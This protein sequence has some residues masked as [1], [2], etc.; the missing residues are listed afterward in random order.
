MAGYSAGSAS[1]QIV[2]DFSGAQKKIG[3][4]FAQQGDI[5][6][7][8]SPNLNQ[9][10]LQAVRTEINATDAAIDVDIDLH[11]VEQKMAVFLDQATGFSMVEEQ[12][13]RLFGPRSILM[14]T[15]VGAFT[16]LAASASAALPVIGLL[17]GMIMAAAGP[18]AV[19]AIGT[20][21][22]G[23]AFKALGAADK[24]SAADA[25][26]AA[27]ARKSAAAQVE[28]AQKGVESAQ[29][30]VEGAARSLENA[31]RGVADA[32]KNV[33]EAQKATA[34]AQ[35]GLNRARDEAV[36]NLQD[37]NMELARASLNEEGAALAVE[38]A[39]IK[40]N[41]ALE[42]GA[43]AARQR[44]AA[45][46]ALQRAQESL[47]QVMDDPRKSDLDRQAATLAVADAQDALND[48]ITQ[49]TVKRELDIKE[50]DL[51]F[52][53]A[54][55]SLE[56]IQTKNQRLA[57]DTAA[58]N[59]AGVE[60]AANVV[61]AKDKVSAAVD[62]E[63]K[64]QQGLADAQRSVLDA[65][66]S[67]TDASV[68]LTDAQA[69]LA[70]AQADVAASANQGSSAQS[71]AAEAMAA[72]SPS[73]QA[74]VTTLR[75]LK[76]A[77]DDLKGAVQESLFAGLADTV[78]NLADKVL[79]NLK[80][81]L[82]GI[83]TELNTGFR[84][85]MDV[86]LQPAAVA[87][88]ATL[89]DNL[90]VS[91]ANL[92]SAAAP[93]TQTFIDLT[94]VGSEFLPQLTSG[95]ADAATKFAGF[96]SN[97]RET[98]QLHDIFQRALDVLGSLFSIIGNLGSGIGNI[99]QAAMPAGDALLTLLDNVTGGLSTL[100][101]SAEGQNSLSTFFDQVVG[102]LG[103]LQ[104]AFEA[105]TSAAVTGLLPAISGLAQAL[106]P[107]VGQALVMF[108]ELVQELAPIIY[109]VL[110]NAIAALV[111]ALIP[112]I[113]MIAEMA[114]ELFPVLAD[115]LTQL[116][117][118]LSAF[119]EA[120]G[121]GLLNT[122]M[123]L[124]PLLQPVLDALI[125]M[126]QTITPLV[127]FLVTFGGAI[128]V[129]VQAFQAYVYVQKLWLILTKAQEVAT[130]KL[131][132][133]QKLL[134][135]LVN[136]SPMG[137]LIL[138]ISLVIA[139]FIA[140]YTNSETFREIV[141][142]AL[143]AVGDAATWMWE[144]AIKPAWEH[145][146]AAWDA[147]VQG[148]V[149]AWNTWLKPAWD[150]VAAA[151]T[152]LY[153]TV[154]RPVFDA[155]LAYWGALITGITWYWEHI[156]QPVWSVIMD[157]AMVLFRILVVV[158]FGAIMLAWTALT[159]GMAWAW[160]HVLKPAWGAIETAAEW[161]W[162][163]VL[164]VYF[165]LIKAGWDGLLNGM[166]WVWKNVLK[167][168]WDAIETAADWLWDNALSPVFTAIGDGWDVLSSGMQ[169]IY[170]VVLKPLLDSFG[171][172]GQGAQTIF[173]GVVA[174][175]KVAWDTLQD[176]L[177]TPINFVIQKVFNEGLFTAWNWAVSSLGLPESWKA[178]VWNQIKDHGQHFADGGR[179]SGY[180][181]HARAD[182]IPI[183][184]TAGEWMQPVAAV[185]QYGPSFMRAV[186]T[187]QFPTELAQGFA[188]GGPIWKTLD[189]KRKEWF[190]GSVLTSSTRNTNDYH[191]KGMAIDIGWAGNNKAKLDEIGRRLV[192][193]APA[194]AEI[195]HNNTASVKNGKVVP[196]SLW[197]AATWADHL[198][199][200]HWAISNLAQL[201]G[202]KAM[203]D[204]SGEDS[205]SILGKLTDAITKPI[206]SLIA[207]FGDNG[208]TKIAAGV[209]KGL[210]GKMW[211]GAKGKVEEFFSNLLPW[212]WGDDDFQGQGKPTTG[213]VQG[214]VR[215]IM[216]AFGF[217][218]DAQ[219]YALDQLVSHE[220]SWNPKAKNPSSTASGL[221][222]LLDGTWRDYRG[223]SS[224]AHARDASVKD[225]AGAGLGYIEDRYGSPGAA[226]SWWRQHKWYDQGG[227][228]PPGLTTVM[229]ATG[230]PE[231]VLTAAEHD[232][233]LRW[234]GFEKGRTDGPTTV[235][236]FVNHGTVLTTD[237]DEL[238]RKSRRGT[239]R[240]LSAA[241]L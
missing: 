39:Q 194:S 28:S 210:L 233:L 81:G 169:T 70:E 49:T 158:V 9:S 92:A 197:G 26:A 133:A 88:F 102:A 29:R 184:A 155:I 215:K 224:A 229:N 154:L 83:A 219:W 112:L 22:V 239:Q 65:Q 10:K 111:T 93:F 183:W 100:L 212:N 104:P 20:R 95:L 117:P 118:V 43:D 77:W 116:S 165:D 79:P 76:G 84:A 34:D 152:W 200:V 132:G 38:E 216:E 142:N 19:L 238:A 222:Q 228:L 17:P 63:Q 195:I 45:T 5:D 129:I 54:K 232:S 120:V 164:K 156:L 177:A 41:E 148:I 193:L 182:N 213:A 52:R 12:F 227:Y 109:P 181:P 11:N 221:F 78:S 230:R 89:L 191:G 159:D 99:F 37:M 57:A 131:T 187:G 126:M 13:K 234:R 98:G 48:T 178:P 137:R 203:A 173:E 87:D 236:G 149:Y 241:G 162:D 106:A 73:A 114:V 122:F 174:G 61:A 217:H 64:A 85:S 21:G 36:R 204:L 40:L 225:Q 171:V 237:L 103:A 33:A 32:E 167:P 119:A 30:G 59:A 125:W 223:G 56:E 147:T 105:L 206:S 44:E 130:M 153:E 23:E 176:I 189:A 160:E 60:G 163:H 31:E 121:E 161:L 214:D 190:P 113:P 35:D 68:N 69:K 220:S 58:A 90:R 145:I 141:Q 144:N 196:P 157:I 136:M 110:A 7:R 72:L 124:L 1:V 97:L 139:A 179:I 146:Q 86:F 198:D 108:A 135:T 175:I 96:I 143:H 62:N 2:P 172:A 27:S 82:S 134:N 107:V 24:S 192:Q 211:D 180:S 140:L 128:W 66:R 127:P 55:A 91:W 235:A 25:T 42:G 115:I 170:D 188:D 199:H 94:T 123:V 138:I 46:I 150:A 14:T 168:V 185:Q 15:G 75:G 201:A 208:F 47:A 202:G 67:V 209:P 74:F 18:L 4:W 53:Q 50:A 186:Q 51:G 3:A 6:M 218:G 240:A 80:T 8:V 226:W 205:G 231:P 71:A 16:A 166:E 101:G 207:Q 151:A